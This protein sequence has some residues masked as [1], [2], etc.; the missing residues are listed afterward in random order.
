MCDLISLLLYLHKYH[1]TYRIL[2]EKWWHYGW[3]PAIAEIKRIDKD[4]E[5][6]IISMSGEPA[7][8]F[9]AAN[10]Q[11]DPSLWQKEFPIGRDVD[12]NGFGKYQQNISLVIRNS[13]IQIYG[14][15]RIIDFRLH[16]ECKQ[17]GSNLNL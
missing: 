10:Y 12:V 6:I 4:Y 16:R 3:T 13:D 15:G 14:L 5:R 1:T 11:Y 7:W 2:S 17:I 9:F 8:I